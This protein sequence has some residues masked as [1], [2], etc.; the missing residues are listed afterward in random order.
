MNDF[1]KK[2]LTNTDDT[3]RF[4]VKSKR[5]GRTYYVEPV[6]NVRTN[7]GSYNPSTGNVE[8]KKGTGKYRG[9]VDVTDSLVTEENG[10]EN[11]VTLDPGQSP[12]TYIS[13]VDS[14]YPDKNNDDSLK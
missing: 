1:N 14:K 2:F 5:T 12:L 11:V 10:L 8:N 13:G 9:S 4:I 7:W 6:G 3:G